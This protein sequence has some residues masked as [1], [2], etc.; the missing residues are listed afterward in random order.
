MLIL[1]RFLPLD[2]AIGPLWVRPQS[3]PCS[4][5]R[6][7][8]IVTGQTLA[9]HCAFEQSQSHLRRRIRGHQGNWRR[10]HVPVMP[11][12][13]KHSSFVA[14]SAFTHVTAC[15]L[16][17]SPYF[18]TAI[19]GLQTFRHLHARPHFFGGSDRRVGLAPTGK[20]RL[21]TARGTARTALAMSIKS[22]SYGKVGRKL[23]QKLANTPQNR[24]RT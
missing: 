10:F 3:S 20:R 16:A 23:V 12:L 5:G 24:K 7:A 6:R 21:V 9:A 13:T 22:A 15:T 11:P 8:I 4:I 19:R 14:C 1:L 2:S 18:V 17:Q